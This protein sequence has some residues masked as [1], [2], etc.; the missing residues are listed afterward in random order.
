[1]VGR[2]I[3]SVK[4]RKQRHKDHPPRKDG[5]P[6]DNEYCSAWRQA[7]FV[8][9]LAFANRVV[10]GSLDLDRHLE[11]LGPIDD[12][13]VIDGLRPTSRAELG[14]LAAAAKSE[15][16]LHRGTGGSMY[17]RKAHATR[18]APMGDQG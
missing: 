2:R 11:G 12:R 9:P 3:S 8:G 4:N 16:S 1:M 15:L 17:T 7:I 6:Q 5:Q 10:L 13:G 14:L 18:E